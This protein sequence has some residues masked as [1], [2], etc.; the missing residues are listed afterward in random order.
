MNRKESIL[1]LKARERIEGVNKKVY[2]RNELL[3]LKK[4]LNSSIKIKISQE[5]F[6]DLLIEN[7]LVQKLTPIS[8]YENPPKRYVLKNFSM[9][10]L[11]CSLYKNAYLSHGTAAFIQG[12][13]H[14]EPK[15]IYLNRE[16]SIKPQLDPGEL[17]QQTLKTAFARKQKQSKYILRYGKTTITLL[18]GK[19]TGRLG[20]EQIRR[21][22][23]EMIK[24]TD[25]ERTLVDITVRPAYA[26]GVEQVLKC[27]QS[28]KDRIS[29]KKLI[30]T[31]ERLN[32]VY[33]YHQ[34][35]GFY[36]QRAGFG[37]ASWLKL[38]KRP[39]QL[40]FYLAH[41]MKQ[42]DYDAEWKIFF[43]KGLSL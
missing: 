21:V 19:N 24:V 14:N 22:G 41:G 4:S 5:K 26:G 9:Y 40:D 39:F 35:V 18:N 29:S 3:Q 37:R 1:L 33:P 38:R 11:A 32:Y 43:P 31:L 42:N 8:P 28:S 23:G 2:S 6:I 16:Q 36:M 20:I 10:E 13:I 27:Y 30:S 15:N 34:A 7:N 12:L 25:L 17:T